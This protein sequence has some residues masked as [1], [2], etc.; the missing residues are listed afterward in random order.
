MGESRRA[1]P[2]QLRTHDDAIVDQRVMDDE[3][4]RPIR[5]ASVETAAACPDTKA[6]QSA[7]S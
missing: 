7:A 4:L 6:T 2:E 1:L 5:V 3:V